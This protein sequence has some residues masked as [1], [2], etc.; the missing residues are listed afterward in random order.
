MYVPIYKSTAQESLDQEVLYELSASSISICIMAAAVDYESIYQNVNEIARVVDTGKITCSEVMACHKMFVR[1]DTLSVEEL[2]GSSN[3]KQL[4]VF[5][6]VVEIQKNT[7][8]L[9]G[10]TQILIACR[11]LDVKTNNEIDLTLDWQVVNNTNQQSIP[12]CAIYAENIVSSSS[13]NSGTILLKVKYQRTSSSTTVYFGRQ[14]SYTAGTGVAAP[15]DID[16][17]IAAQENVE[18]MDSEDWF[19]N[20]NGIQCCTCACRVGQPLNPSGGG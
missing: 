16:L 9:P 10:S 5:A 6:D 4:I 18:L 13:G 1:L 20:I 17:S 12:R 2:V 14:F 8:T 11:I 19:V 7:F 3:V 15:T